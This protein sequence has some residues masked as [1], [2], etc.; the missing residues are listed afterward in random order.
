MYEFWVSAILS[1]IMQDI[2]VIIEDCCLKIRLLSRILFT[3]G[4]SVTPLT[5]TIVFVL[6]GVGLDGESQSI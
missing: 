6:F 3:C 1:L 5:M 4:F 2:H